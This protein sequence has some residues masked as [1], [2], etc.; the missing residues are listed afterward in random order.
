MPKRAFMEVEADSSEDNSTS[1]ETGSLV[2]HA[3]LLSKP[4]FHCNLT[5]TRR[6]LITVKGFKPGSSDAIHDVTYLPTQAF[7]FFA[8]VANTTYQAPFQ[9]MHTVFPLCEYHHADIKLHSF[10]IGLRR[11]V[12]GQCSS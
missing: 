4:Y 12:H 6:N 3:R 9:P 8:L 10:N 5:I 1:T 2:K 7:D 11:R